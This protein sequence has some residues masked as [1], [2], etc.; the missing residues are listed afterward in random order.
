L[1][2][3][4]PKLLTARSECEK[5]A[6]AH[7]L[8]GHQ[9]SEARERVAAAR[10]EHESTAA[11]LK[12][13]Q[14]RRT[15]EAEALREI[16]TELE[17]KTAEAVEINGA[18]AELD[19]AVSGD[20]R[21]RAERG[22]LTS[23]EGLERELEKAK[24][25]FGSLGVPPPEIVRDEE[26]VLRANVEEA[27][28]HVTERE[29]EAE[30]AGEELE[31]C[32]RRYLEVVNQTLADYRRRVRE[33]SELAGVAS[34]TQLPSLVNDD[35]VLD[36]AR[37]EVAFGFD[38]KNLVPVGHPSFS[39]G[40]QVIAGLILLMAMAES[41]SHGFFMLDEPFAHLS[42][43]RVDHVGR[44]LRSTRSQFIITA[45]TTLERAQ[46]DPAALLIVLQKKRGAEPYAPAPIVAKVRQ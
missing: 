44:F 42:L 4:L 30:S 2:K 24:G 5:A 39:G 16:Q 43:D 20:L 22:E 12:E 17:A 34:E 38:G 27:E 14:F 28:R 36:E 19:N 40:Q 10:G 29:R 23:P 7:A 8:A 25:H 45:P 9:V 26:R 15:H 37:I 3:A 33:I 13:A 1:S 6:A 21:A 18:I 31:E 41:D 32:R 46:F 11:R 35:R